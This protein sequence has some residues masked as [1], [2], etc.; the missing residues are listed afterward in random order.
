MLKRLTVEALKRPSCHVERSETSRIFPSSAAG[1]GHQ[2]F[3]A[4]LRMT[5]V[6]NASPVEPFNAYTNP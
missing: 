2:R 4:S 6:L 3:F 5:P 1:I